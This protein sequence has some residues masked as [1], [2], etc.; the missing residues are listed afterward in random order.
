[1]HPRP[2][3]FLLT[4]TQSLW[5]AEQRIDHLRT[6]TAFAEEAAALGRPSVQAFAWLEARIARAVSALA[7]SEAKWRRMRGGRGAR[8][9][10][11]P[12]AADSGEEELADNGARMAAEL[13]AKDELL[14]GLKAQVEGLASGVRALQHRWPQGPRAAA[15]RS[16]TA[17]CEPTRA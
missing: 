8:W 11:A 13:R 7:A 1:M 15:H 9:R 10:P 6:A 5:A 14:A 16:I 12:A 2:R 4:L 3:A 17:V